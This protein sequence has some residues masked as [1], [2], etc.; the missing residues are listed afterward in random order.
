MPFFAVTALVQASLAPFVG[1]AQDAWAAF[2]Q[3]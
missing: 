1:H 2:K 3:R